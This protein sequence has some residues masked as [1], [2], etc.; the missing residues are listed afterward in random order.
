MNRQYFNS[1]DLSSNGGQTFFNADSIGTA[2]TVTPL[3]RDIHHSFTDS[4]NRQFRVIIRK[5]RGGRLDKSVFALSLLAVAILGCIAGTLLHFSGDGKNFSTGSR[6]TSSAE[7]QTTN[8]L[9][10]PP[11]QTRKDFAETQIKPAPLTVE[12]SLRAQVQTINV[13]YKPL[14]RTTENVDVAANTDFENVAESASDISANDKIISEI[15][16]EM[17]RKPERNKSGEAQTVEQLKNDVR[18]W[19]EHENKKDK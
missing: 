1:Q 7:I 3:N 16:P 8:L 10:S 18:N 19:F 15:K 14:P 2:Q 6:Y 13:S 11:A 5:S 17:K 9:K 4:D 12:P